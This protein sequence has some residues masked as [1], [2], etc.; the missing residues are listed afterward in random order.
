MRAL[1]EGFD[2]LCLLIIGSCL[3]SACLAQNPI[4]SN[5]VR[6]KKENQELVKSD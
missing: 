4:V 1:W 5:R 6:Q 2:Y 3:D